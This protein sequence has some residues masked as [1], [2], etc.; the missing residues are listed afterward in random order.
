MLNMCPM[1]TDCTVAGVWSSH[2][3]HRVFPLHFVVFF[4]IANVFFPDL[5]F[6][7]HEN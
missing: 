5:I 1:R 7:G 6:P 4:L 2:E 3:T